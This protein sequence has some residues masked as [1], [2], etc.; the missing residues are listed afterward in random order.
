MEV[1]ESIFGNTL[2]VENGIGKGLGGYYEVAVL[3]VGEASYD[4][5]GNTELLV[6]GGPTHTLGM[7][8]GISRNM[9][10]KTLKEAVPV[11]EGVCV[12]EWL[13]KLPK[14]ES[15]A[16][17]VFDTR[18]PKTGRMPMGAAAKG[19]G[20]ALRRRGG[21]LLAEPE[22][23]FVGDIAG[24][25]LDDEDAR[26]TEWAKSLIPTTADLTV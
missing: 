24:P 6:V 11:S 10:K 7:G 8:R 22:S 9:G 16:V 1:Y 21:R 14:I 26:A 2:Q 15:V 23:F 20:A 19:I 4:N 13:A 18:V 17:A 5:V 25:L 12:R 3:E